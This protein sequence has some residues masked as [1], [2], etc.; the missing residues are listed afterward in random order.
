MESTTAMLFSKANMN[1]ELSKDSEFEE[2]KEFKKDEKQDTPK[3]STDNISSVNSGINSMSI[4]SKE[5]N[6]KEKDLIKYNDINIINGSKE[7]KDF[8]FPI[9][10]SK[11][12]EESKNSEANILSAITKAIQEQ[13]NSDFSSVDLK[14]PDN[15]KPKS[16]TSTTQ[17]TSTNLIENFQSNLSQMF[18][19]NYFSIPNPIV[20]KYFGKNFYQNYH[21]SNFIPISFTCSLDTHRGK[22]TQTKTVQEEKEFF[23]KIIKIGEARNIS[24]FWEIFQH[25]RK[26]A[27]C[28]IGT[29]YHIFKRGIIPMWED[30]KNK[31]GGKLS[32]LLTWKYVNVIWEEVTFNFAKGMLPY[33][34]YINGIVISMRPKFSV[35]SFWIKTNTSSVVEQIR[36][37]LSEMIQAPSTNCIDFIPFN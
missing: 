7:Q 5:E 31:N 2:P 17:T 34:D 23:E 25:L 27:Q 10:S 33:F 12:Q 30:E 14:I 36:T 11:T 6:A 37:A 29:D 4:N 28:P 1:A 18:I 19:P 22:K 24:E 35:L 13:S 20:K 16:I 3:E 9:V 26:P 32:V 21:I 15:M 8:F